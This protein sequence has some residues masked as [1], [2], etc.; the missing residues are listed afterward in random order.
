VTENLRVLVTVHI[1]HA[2]QKASYQVEHVIE[3]LYQYDRQR[4]V[5][6]AIENSTEKLRG[7]SQELVNLVNGAGVWEDPWDDV[8]EEDP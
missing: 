2:K 6:E 7:Q 4:L 1:E 3:G 5:E 8:N